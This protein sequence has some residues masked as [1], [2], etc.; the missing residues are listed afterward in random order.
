MSAYPDIDDVVDFL[1]PSATDAERDF[2]VPSAVAELLTYGQ[3][4]TTYEDLT[5]NDKILFDKAA[6]Y[7]AAY[8][9]YTR[10]SSTSIAGSG[11]VK[12]MTQD[13]LSVEYDVGTTSSSSGTSSYWLSE[14]QRLLG[15]LCPEALAN[16][17]RRAQTS[18]PVSN[19]PNSADP[20]DSLYQSD[21][22]RTAEVV[23]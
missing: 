5:G 22:E 16:P 8:D 10:P 14:F 12:K 17:L 4:F 7:K 9:I 20:R 1:L 3:C 2:A 15:I 23:V 6:G 11:D 21:V 19:L 13:G 18:V